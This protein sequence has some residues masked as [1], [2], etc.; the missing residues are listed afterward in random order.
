[1]SESTHTPGPWMVSE[2]GS[3]CGF[4]ILSGNH[5]DGHLSI[6][7]VDSEANARLIA[8]A[9]AL[10]EWLEAIMDQGEA[11]RRAGDN[12]ITVGAGMAHGILE[13]IRKAKGE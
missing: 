11:Q 8:S 4:H 10:L 9:P 12:V 2:D 7:K 13:T 3:G 6:A 1:M 5:W